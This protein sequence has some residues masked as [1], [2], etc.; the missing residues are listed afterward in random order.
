M[1]ESFWVPK[2]YFDLAKEYYYTQLEAD[3]QTSDTDQEWKKNFNKLF[4]YRIQLCIFYTK[5]IY[6]FR[7][8]RTNKKNLFTK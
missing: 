3:T 1:T 5:N 8:Q 4:F 2:E 7:I 6:L